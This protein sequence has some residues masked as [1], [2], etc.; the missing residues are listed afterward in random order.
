MSP[1]QARHF[2]FPQ[3]NACAVAC[4]WNTQAAI[5]ATVGR[6]SVEPTNEVRSVAPPFAE[7]LIARVE[8]CAR[9]L[10]I[11][12]HRHLTP[13]DFRHGC[14]IVALGKNK[15]SKDFTNDEVTRVVDLFRVLAQPLSIKA[16]QHWQDPLLSKKENLIIQAKKKAQPEYIAAI[17]AD[18]FH[19][20]V[21]EDLSIAQLQKLCFTLNERQKSWGARA[22]RVPRSAPSPNAP[23]GP[24]REGANRDTRGACA[25]RKLE[26]VKG[27]F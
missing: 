11:S 7:E 4:G 10:A 23:A 26:Y 8:T 22:P 12:E 17:T 27:P 15:S 16:I 18:K 5:M 13:N 3:W 19:T 1:E 21:L 6:D 20:R 25:P 24:V 9:Q 2:Y 14:T